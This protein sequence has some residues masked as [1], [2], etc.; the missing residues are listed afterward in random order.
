M[1]VLAR[2]TLIRSLIRIIVTGWG[3]PQ[4]QFCASELLSGD[5]AEI[6]GKTFFQFFF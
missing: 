2:P 3:S 4:Q 5:V 1:P 6:L